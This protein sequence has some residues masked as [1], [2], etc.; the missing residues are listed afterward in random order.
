V[1]GYSWDSAGEHSF[2]TTTQQTKRYK[3]TKQRNHPKKREPDKDVRGKLSQKKVKTMNIPLE[4]R[5]IH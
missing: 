5:T 2:I 4:Y 3:L 1:T